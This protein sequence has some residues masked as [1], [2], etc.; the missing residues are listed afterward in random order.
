M[1]NKLS[2]LKYVE[3][4]LLKHFSRKRERKGEL[5]HGHSLIVKTLKEQGLHLVLSL[6]A[7]LQNESKM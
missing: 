2:D 5:V 3:F 4:S 6:D 7:Q 1:P